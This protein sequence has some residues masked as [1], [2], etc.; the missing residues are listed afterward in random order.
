MSQSEQP[1]TANPH[2]LL[3]AEEVAA[4]LKVPLSWVYDRTRRGAI[5]L[6]RIGKYCRF[7]PPEIEAWNK[8]GCPEQWPAESA[9]QQK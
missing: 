5:P 2:Q 9:G 7:S 4:L 3:T 6:R 1:T 8:A